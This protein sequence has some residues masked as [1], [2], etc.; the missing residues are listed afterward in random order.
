MIL[1]LDAGPRLIAKQLGL[2]CNME[3][4]QFEPKDTDAVADAYIAA[5]D[6][7]TYLPKLYTEA[8]SRA[9]VEQVLIPNNEV[10]VVEDE[11]EVIGFLGFADGNLRHH[12]SNPLITIGEQG[13]R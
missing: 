2:R 6:E 7:M 8:E 9:F 1:D 5:L 10:W 13:L 11:A 3:F 12:G 4:R